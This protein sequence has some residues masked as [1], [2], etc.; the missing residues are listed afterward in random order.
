MA[1][2]GALLLAVFALLVQV[3][4]CQLFLPLGLFRLFSS[5]ASPGRISK[6]GYS[7]FAQITDALTNLPF[8]LILKTIFSVFA[9]MLALLLS[10]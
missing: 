1:E 7:N 6:K 2:E 5:V 9:E 10:A 3:S 8:S 4:L